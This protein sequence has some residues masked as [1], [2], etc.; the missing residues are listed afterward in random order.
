MIDQIRLYS[1]D[2]GSGTRDIGDNPIIVSI[3]PNPFQ[4]ASLVTLRREFNLVEY[5]LF[6]STGGRV[7]SGKKNKCSSF[8]IERKNL[9]SGIYFLQVSSDDN[10]ISK[11]RILIF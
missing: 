1:I 8:T 7:L 4:S 10:L 3:N 2:L 5:S 9:P 11:E 6:N